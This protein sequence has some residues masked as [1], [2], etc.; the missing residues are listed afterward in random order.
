M[1]EKTKK[2]GE[3]AMLSSRQ[4][5][6]TI[7]IDI[8]TAFFAFCTVSN[9]LLEDRDFVVVAG[10]LLLLLL[11]LAIKMCTKR[12]A[13]ARKHTMLLACCYT[14]LFWFRDTCCIYKCMQLLHCIDILVATA[15]P[16]NNKQ[17]THF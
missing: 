14:E 8:C 12:K 9:F 3:N 7:L 4:N 17:R 15:K 10:F 16:L 6:N 1:E 13:H 5:I 11:W 2:N